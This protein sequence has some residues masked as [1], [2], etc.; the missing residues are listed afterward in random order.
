[1]TARRP[2]RS[3]LRDALAVG[4][5]ADLADA[6]LAVL[7]VSAL[8]L[9]ARL[10]GL[11]SR[12]A[13]FDEGRVAYWT[14][15]YADTGAFH[16]R[17]IIHGPFVQ[18]V[19]RAV[20]ELFGATDFTM[21]LVVAVL[22]AALP[23]TALLYRDRLRDSELIAAAAFLAFNPVLLYYSR[24]FRSSV[25]VAGFAFAAL[26]FAV[27]SYDRASPRALYAAAAALALAFAAK[28]N[29]AVYV[30]CWLGAGAL[31]LD[32]SLMSPRSAPT[33]ADAVRARL[34]RARDAVRTEA[35]RR[36]VGRWAAHVVG[37]AVVFLL[38]SLFFYAPRDPNGLGL[39]SALSEGRV[40]PLLEATWA[41]VETGYR[42]W[43][44]GASEPNCNK[45]T[46]VG[47]YAC[48]LSRFLETL[49]RYAAALTLFAVVGA[50]AERYA[51]DRPRPLVMLAAYWGFVSVLGY[52]LG[53]DIY[54]AW[55]TVNALVPL[56][57]PAGVGLALVW[58]WGRAALAAED[59]VGV[60][61]A[62]VVVLLVGA[63]FGVTAAGAVYTAPTAEDNGL[64]QYAQPQQELRASL[65]AVDRATEDGR[66]DLLLYGEELTVAPGTGGPPAPV[67][68]KMVATLPLQW[69]VEA[70]D[71]SA[72]CA[73]NE[74]ALERRLSDFDP[75]VVMAHVS[76]R[77]ELAARL[78][79][80][81]AR[82]VHL[83]TT[84]REVVVF[85]AP[86]Y[87]AESEA[88]SDSD[89]DSDADADV[90]VAPTA[91][92]AVDRR[93]RRPVAT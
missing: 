90:E 62:A 7:A 47:G 75:A 61:V 45:E 49:W 43:F 54:G 67:C 13:H 50:L 82:T 8:G 11:G 53:T 93:R 63:Q 44:G 3:A 57:I 26:G 80:Y 78:E 17:F 83:R 72:T 5:L 84:G 42:Y 22:G 24:F 6:T 40:G 52:P 30:L 10:V 74:T 21:R 55:I 81:A 9:V 64:V 28:E 89:S 31:L 60:G 79:G 25:L 77:S 20:F 14:M 46:I 32:F 1:M 69:Y 76:H 71:A 36:R 15:E 29:A 87:A 18:H 86:E 66:V 68:S 91:E 92:T 4:P 23:L 16:Y 51:T 48:Y 41:D 35:A 65:D 2:D 38:V 59:G 58:R 19:T 73:Y 37:A 88:A 85:V 70:S 39:W 56:A 27:R 34:R 12:V 33:G